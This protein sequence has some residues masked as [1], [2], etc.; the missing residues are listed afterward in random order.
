MYQTQLKVVFWHSFSCVDTEP[1]SGTAA[2]SDIGFCVRH[3]SSIGFEAVFWHNPLDRG[4]G[5]N[6]G[7][8]YG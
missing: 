5:V 7:L 1:V 4:G 8:V 3:K 2:V 6:P